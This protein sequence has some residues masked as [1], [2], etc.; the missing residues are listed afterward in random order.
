MKKRSYNLII[1]G[2][3]A[4]IQPVLT[5]EYMTAGAHP[6]AFTVRVCEPVL[7]KTPLGYNALRAIK[8]N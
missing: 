7:V 1:D 2:H 3:D 6:Y 5:R 8:E 4:F